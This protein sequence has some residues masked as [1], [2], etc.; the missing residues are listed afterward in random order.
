MNNISEE[1]RKKVMERDNFTCQKCGFKDITSKELE[2]HHIKPKIFQGDPNPE[3]LV[4]LCPICHNYAPDNEISFKRYL[5][6][7]I[8]SKIL[9]TFRK[10]DYSISKR[11]KEG[12]RKKAEIGR[13]IT[14]PPLG[15]KFING[16]LEPEPEEKKV[17]QQIF[18][19]FL[20]SAK[21]L[22]QLAKEHSFTTRGMIKLLKNT[23]Y[24]GKVKFKGSFKGNH[25]AII[26]E[27]TFSMAQEKLS[28][29]SFNT[30]MAKNVSLIDDVLVEGDSRYLDSFSTRI[31]AQFMLKNAIKV[32]KKPIPEIK[33]PTEINFEID[34]PQKTAKYIAKMLL[35]QEGFSENEIFIERLFGEDKPDVAALNKE[36]EVFVEC[37]SCRVNKVISYLSQNKELWVLTNGAYPWD[38]EPIQSAMEWFVFKKGQDWDSVFKDYQL[39]LLEI[40]KKV[41]NPLD[42]KQ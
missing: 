35:K 8:D 25:E 3:N 36:R 18:D 22:S 29:I 10:S 11:T 12:M 1:I 24:I 5:N 34:G 21:S 20:N 32:E 2:I 23:T 42:T 41:K 15:Y 31:V 14:R 38:K 7:K 6:E 26:S 28:K 30:A 13:H 37:F 33:A 40:L 27:E 9:K 4:V 17:V 16:R 19:K 39:R